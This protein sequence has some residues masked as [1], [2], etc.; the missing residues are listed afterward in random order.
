M[1]NDTDLVRSEGTIKTDVPL[2][3]YDAIK[4]GNDFTMI[5][6]KTTRIAWVLCMVYIAACKKSF[7]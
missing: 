2:D 3:T 5:P 6:E 1:Q 7:S 4:I